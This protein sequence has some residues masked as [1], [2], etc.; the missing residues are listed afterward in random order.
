MINK[1]YLVL[2]SSIL[3]GKCTSAPG[4][5]CQVFDNPYEYNTPG[6]L[7]FRT[8]CHENVGDDDAC[9]SDRHNPHRHITST[10]A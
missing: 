6:T 10:S 4:I 3:S 2:R 7:Y 1:K 5:E 9:F 8:E